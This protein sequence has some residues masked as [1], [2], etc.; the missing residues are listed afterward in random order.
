MK[1]HM[2]EVFAEPAIGVIIGCNG[3]VWIEALRDRQAKQVAPVSEEER[4][5]IAI[6]RN[7]ISLLDK[8]KLPIFRDIILKVIEEQQLTQTEPRD[9]L[10][11]SDAMLSSAV[12][13]IDDEIGAMKPID[14]QQI[15]RDMEQADFKK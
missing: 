7:A 14:F 8:A 5:K 15:M 6:L 1:N 3:Y 9:M 11:N 4:I 2:L 13:M 10:A 12:K